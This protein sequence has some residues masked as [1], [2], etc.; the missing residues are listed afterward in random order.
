VEIQI[1]SQGSSLS[2]SLKSTVLQPTAEATPIHK[3][4]VVE[5]KWLSVRLSPSRSISTCRCH[6]THC[7]SHTCSSFNDITQTT[8]ATVMTVKENPTLVRYNQLK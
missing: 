7:S 5:K 6:S 8:L 3:E 4:C 2:I 1:Q